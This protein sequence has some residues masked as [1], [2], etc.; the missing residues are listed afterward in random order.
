MCIAGT[1]RLAGRYKLA[2]PFWLS[3]P[4]DSSASI[5][6]R[7]GIGTL[8]L[9]MMELE[10]N[11]ASRS[12]AVL[13]ASACR[14]RL[15][16]YLHVPGRQ[17]A[18]PSRILRYAN[19]DH[20]L[21]RTMACQPLSAS[22]DWRRQADL[23]PEPRRL[24]AAHCRLLMGSPL[25]SWWWIGRCAETCRSPGAASTVRQ[26]W[27]RLR[28]NALL[29]SLPTCGPTFSLSLQVAAFLR[30]AAVLQPIK[31]QSRAPKIARRTGVG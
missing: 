16:D 10:F 23:K 25:P 12:I 11:H 20:V 24:T 4:I 5:S 15:R 6:S 27:R 2:E 3:A 8:D 7:R 9:M 29:A 17:P 21:R 19:H 13:A 1:G 30:P 26:T 18:A 14:Y 22:G 31:L 28:L